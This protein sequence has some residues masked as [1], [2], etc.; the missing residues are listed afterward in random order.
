MLNL[1]RDNVQSFGVKFIVAVVAIMML[2]FGLSTYQNQGI[3]TLAEVDG[4]EIRLENYQRVYEHEERQLREQYQ[5]NTEQFIKIFRLKSRV[6]QQ[7]INNAVLLKNARI[8]GLE[9][10]DLELAMAVYENPAFQ[11]DNRFDQ[12]KYDRLLKNYRTNKI[13]YEKD[14]RESLLTQKYLN[15]LN[16]GISFSRKYVES[17]Y[18]RFNTELDVQMIELIPELFADQVKITEKQ[19]KSYYESHKT[20]FEQKK[21][22]VIDYLLLTADD[23][24]DKV[25]VRDKEITKYYD[26]HKN[27]EF[28]IKESYNSRHILIPVEGKQEAKD[29][30][31]A[32]KQADRIYAELRKNKENFAK[33]A[34]AHSADPGS[35]KNGGNLGWVTQ[36]SFVQAFEQTVASLKKGEISKPVK[37]QFGY[38]IIELIDRKEARIR[39]LDEV[40]DEITDAVRSGKAKRRLKNKVSKLLKVEEGAIKASMQELATTMGK[41]VQQTK[42]FDDEQKL[43]GLDYSY[44]LYTALASKAL[45][46]RD[47]FEL[48]AD[49]GMIVYEIRKIID[50]FIKPLEEVKTQVQ[51][52]AR[53]EAE[54]AFVKQKGIELAKSIKNKKQY[55]K[56]IKLLKTKATAIKF[57]LVDNNQEAGNMDF[58]TGVFKMSPG[59]IKL[60]TK[61]QSD[62]LVYLNSKT[63]PQE[64][65]KDDEIKTMENQIQRQKATVMLN[66]II[67]NTRKET[68]IKYNQKLLQAL[69]IES[70]S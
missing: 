60:I 2:T 51:M 10:S 44:S 48:A 65:V 40:K 4:V 34:M 53:Q 1:I 14:L 33:L 61:G 20:D 45:G 63:E 29:D 68:E 62:V 15:F 32:K 19:I 70:L 41:K 66:G 46:D 23:M 52:F 13:A 55:D 59:D 22:F 58:K 67:A 26:K 21:Q 69:Q 7:L 24:K 38:H 43:E 16:S 9:V 18:K 56:L 64:I 11:T 57:K 42:S 35:K 27:T 49:E 47:S 54:K 28:S 39:P 3:N 8:N 6:M 50:P 25:I 37:S 12:K 30:E 17:E 36:G 31:K 5:E